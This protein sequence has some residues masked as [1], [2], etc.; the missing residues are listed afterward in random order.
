MIVGNSDPMC[1]DA[2]R[3]SGGAAMR[4]PVDRGDWWISG[5]MIRLWVSLHDCIKWE[6]SHH[7]SDL[8]CAGQWHLPEYS[9][10]VCDKQLLMWEHKWWQGKCDAGPNETGLLRVNCGGRGKLYYCPLRLL[11]GPW[12]KLAL[13]HSHWWLVDGKPLDNKGKEKDVGRQIA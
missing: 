7:V 10:P 11:T 1:H 12:R 2:I 8:F 5:R 4:S 9:S 3:Y 6:G 13:H